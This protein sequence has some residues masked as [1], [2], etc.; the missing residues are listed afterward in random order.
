MD[1]NRTSLILK[2]IISS[3][4]VK[5]W[6]A[7]V[8]FVM[9]P[10]TL[11]CLGAYQNGVWLTISSLLVWMDQMDIG[12]GNGLRNRLAIHIAHGEDEE[13]RKVVSSTMAML[14]CISFV[15]MCLLSML[16]QWTE[17]NSP[18]AMPS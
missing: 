4:F 9:V 5:G 2:N 3:F 18:M 15:I 13:A 17:V 12:L 14:F 10:L 7:I 16:V 8:V 11:K 1:S 6:S